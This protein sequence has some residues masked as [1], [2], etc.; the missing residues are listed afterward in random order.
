MS[1]YYASNVHEFLRESE[2]AIMGKLASQHRHDLEPQQRGAWAEQITLLKHELHDINGFLFLEFTIPRMGKRADCII[3]CG[4]TVFVL[5]FKNGADSFDK[6]AIDQAHDYALDLKDFHRGS[7]ELQIIPILIATNANQIKP[8]VIYASDNVAHPV[9]LGRTGIGAF[10]NKY[11]QNSNRLPIDPIKWS[12]SG[13]APT[14]TIIEAARSLYQNN[15][16]PE[17]MRSGADA[18]NLDQTTERISAIIDTCKKNKKKAICFV[19]GVPGAGKT[20]AGL[21]VATQRRNNHQD[22]NA[23]FLSGN[24]PLVDVLREALA[25]DSAKRTGKKKGESERQV[26]AF[27]QNI[28]HF[29]DENFESTRA[30]HE[31]V[32]IFDEAQRAWDQKQVENFMKRKRNIEAFGRSESKFLIEVMDRHQDWCV[33]VCL[34]GGGQ[35]INK[36]EAGISEWIRAVLDF[37]PQWEVHASPSIAED[38][39]VGND[40]ALIAFLNSTRVVKDESLHL[41]TCIRS[42]RASKLSTFIAELLKGNIAEAV[43]L[44]SET[45]N[46]PIF[47]TRDLNRAKD[48]L[49]TRNRGSRRCGMIASSGAARL[50]P[51]GIYVNCSPDPK[52]W[53]LNDK[54]D[55]RSSNYLELTATEFHVQGL[56][57]DWA[58]VCWDAD[59]RYANGKW[60]HYNFKGTKWTHMHSA[61]EQ[62]YLL[63]AYRVLLTRAREGL[64]I[65]VPKGNDNDHTTLREYYDGTWNHLI[66][67]GITPLA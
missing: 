16:V 51:E 24:G 27:I 6:E 53:F 14:P 37:Y 49:R 10:I 44:R 43:K 40:T 42:F 64:V 1:S 35:E 31:H 58:C 20:L 3:I 33:I 15:K 25:R 56:E 9:C 13:Y 48:W 63:N 17:I 19:T 41:S 55:V 34:I 36:G 21:N 59:L 23:V 12:Q 38:N 62:S 32:A 2:H 26:S 30:P 67:C 47:I 18:K 29:R 28:H 4:S 11:S 46:Y 50:Q 57:L 60:F 8:D 61:T 5:E 52:A 45:P 54:N 65:F 22:E 7:H 39:Y 66:A